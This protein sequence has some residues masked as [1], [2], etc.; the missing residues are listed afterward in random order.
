M[1]HFVVFFGRIDNV[2]G[3]VIVRYLVID[4]E[5]EISVIP[6]KL[7]ERRLAEGL[8]SV[9]LVAREAK[10]EVITDEDLTCAVSDVWHIVDTK[11]NLEY[12]EAF[13]VETMAS[14]LGIRELEVS[15]EG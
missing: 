15:G 8:L 2:N 5:D 14:M 12:Y 10:G 3:G 1:V 9:H 11:L 6:P 4:F 7:F 13:D